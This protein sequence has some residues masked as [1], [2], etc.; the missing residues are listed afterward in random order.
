MR[1]GRRA[2][3]HGSGEVDI[4]D[5]GEDFEVELFIATKDAGGVDEDVERRERGEQLLDGVGVGDVEVVRL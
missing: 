4:E 2:H 5:L 1:L 3:A